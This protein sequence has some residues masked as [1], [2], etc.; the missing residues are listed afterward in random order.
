MNHTVCTGSRPKEA[1]GLFRCSAPANFFKKLRLSRKPGPNKS[2]FPA[3][4]MSAPTRG[5]SLPVRQTPSARFLEGRVD[6]P[7]FGLGQ[8]GV[9]AG[10][11][12]GPPL[13]AQCAC[14]RSHPRA[15][16]RL[17]PIGSD[18][19]PS[20]RVAPLAEI[21]GGLEGG[22]RRCGSGCPSPEK[23]GMRARAIVGLRLPPSPPPS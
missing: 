19:L 5:K 1:L 20:F 15:R 18:F 17:C 10:G 4:P 11:R 14:A 8:E 23:Q 2:G 12:V 13:S 6:R 16:S 21:G 22:K 7:R 9:L 3:P